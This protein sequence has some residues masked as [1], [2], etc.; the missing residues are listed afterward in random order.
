MSNQ[1]RTDAHG[2]CCSA[3]FPV[4]FLQGLENSWNKH[5]QCQELLHRGLD[6]LGFTFVADNPVSLRLYAFIR[7]THYEFV[8]AVDT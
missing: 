7:C 4:F 3:I 1:K 2:N 5:R 6:E 8:M